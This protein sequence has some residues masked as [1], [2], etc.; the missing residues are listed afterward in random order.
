MEKSVEEV[1]TL[2]PTAQATLALLEV[3]ILIVKLVLDFSAKVKR[4]IDQ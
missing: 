1:V 2:G 3:I 4:A